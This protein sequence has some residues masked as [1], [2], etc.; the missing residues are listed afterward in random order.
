[1]RRLPQSNAEAPNTGVAGFVVDHTPLPSICA[2]SGVA[3]ESAA[4]TGH[5]R[6]RCAQLTDSKPL[7]T[8]EK[9]VIGSYQFAPVT[10]P[11]SIRPNG[12]HQGSNPWR[13]QG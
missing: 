8:P 6:K 1:V 7:G 13:P 2:L 5:R 12:S 10:I 11:Y 3:G 9:M 4:V